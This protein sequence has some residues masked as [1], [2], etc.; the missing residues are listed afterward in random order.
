MDF[1][2]GHGIDFH[3]L[4]EDENRPMMLG[5]VKIP[6]LLAL[7]GHSDSDVVLHA[8]ADAVLGASGLGD[9][10]DFFPDTDPDLKNMDSVLIMKHA[11]EGAEKKG[12]VP[13]NCDITLIA[14]KPRISIYKPALKKSLASILGIS[15]D[16]VGFKATTT[17]KMG[18]IGREEG[19]GCHASVLLKKS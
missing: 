3:R 7:E 4:I 14:E 11:L 12:Y 18:F 15:E 9:I 8:L 1:R 5:G 17:E 19:L 6:G 2:I 10:G 13:V 16:A